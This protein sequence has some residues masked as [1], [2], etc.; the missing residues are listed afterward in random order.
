MSGNSKDVY[1]SQLG[2]HEN[3]IKVIKKHRNTAYRKPIAE[4]SIRAFREIKQLY[5]DNSKIILDSGCGVGE[6]S[7]N[8]AKANP[9]H[10]VI[11]IDRSLD[12]LERN[13]YFKRDK[14]VKNYRLLRADLVDIWRLMHREKMIFSQHFILY[15]NPYPKA[16]DLTKRWHGHPVFSDMLGLSSKIEV[17]SNW[18]IYLEEFRQGSEFLLPFKSQIER[19]V[20]KSPLTPFE[21][22]YDLSDHELFRLHLSLINA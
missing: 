21:K 19:L 16:T 22:K 13:S 3:L 5:S 18:K 14:S 11:G 7:Y 20:I 12:R 15:P 9:E 6:S 8:L 2:V 17:R 4:H 10:F 1:S